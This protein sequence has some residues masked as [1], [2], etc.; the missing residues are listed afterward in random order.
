[1]KRHGFTMIELVFVI[2]V[3]GILA[4]V[5]LP[6]LG[7]SLKLAQISKAQGDVAAIRSA[8]ASARQKLLVTGTNRYLS[9][10]DNSASTGNGQKLF[11][12]NGTDA[13]LNY[14]VY[15]KSSG[16]HWLKQANLS[17]TVTKYKFSVDGTY[18]IFWYDSSDGGFDCHNADNTGDALVNCKAIVE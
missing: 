4:A 7:S 17:G 14:P 3:L 6:K 18:T 10:L 9:T 12:Q 1:M 2:V 8:I 13:I 11:D 15:S 16:G 5:A